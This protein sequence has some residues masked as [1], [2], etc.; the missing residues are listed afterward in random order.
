LQASLPQE[1]T[2]NRA[3]V[4]CRAADARE[5]FHE[6]LQRCRACGYVSADLSLTDEELSRLYDRGFF[7][8]GDFAD[9]A[10]DREYHTRNFRLR[11]RV[12]RRFLDPA[13]HRRLLEIG[14]A[15]GFFLDVVRRD[16]ER[17][18]GIDLTDEGVRHTRD[19]LGLDAVQDDFLRHDFAGE[20]F[21]VTCMWDT[22]EHV[23]RPDLYLEKIAALTEP[24]ALLALTT[25]DIDSLNARLR[26]RRWRLI[27]L[28]A[29]LHYFSARTITRLLERH[30][31]EVVHL[32]H[33]GYYRS[34]LHMAYAVLAVRHGRRE[35]FERL[36]RTRLLN[37]GFYLNL[38]DIMYVVARKR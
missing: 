18:L 26:G 4:V 6:G 34:A 22:I 15:Y 29:H 21:D 37:W 23:R 16:F 7:H 36:R 12:L 17:V 3:C 27:M 9:Y 33:C 38:Y 20:R 8:E 32:E 13:R 14:S 25:G 10:A 19:A 30:G 1:S 28:P 24:G 5:P 31:F 35:L 11:R 2:R